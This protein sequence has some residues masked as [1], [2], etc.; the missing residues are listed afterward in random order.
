MRPPLRGRCRCGSAGM[1]PCPAML[2]FRVLLIVHS[3]LVG[4]LGLTSYVLCH[5]MSPAVLRIIDEHATPDFWVHR[6][7]CEVACASE[8][9]RA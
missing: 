5:T 9:S 6:S 1:H 4:D 8:L 7:V 2:T 3:I